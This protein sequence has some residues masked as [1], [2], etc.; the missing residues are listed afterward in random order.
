MPDDSA[1]GAPTKQCT[2]C[3]VHL[4]RAAF[5][6]RRASKDGLQPTCRDCTRAY[7]ALHRVQHADRITEYRAGRAEEQRAYMAAWRPGY[8]AANRDR[9]AAHQAEY[10]R[11]NAV[12]YRR[13]AAEW[14]R[15]NPERAAARSREYRRTHL[16]QVTAQQ[17]EWHL[18]NPERSSATIAARK[19]RKRGADAE[20]I[21]RSVVWE[22]DGGTCRLCGIPA[23]PGQWHLEHLV[24]LSRGGP[25][26][27]ANVA[28]SHPACNLAKSTRTLAEWEA[29][30]QAG[31]TT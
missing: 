15:A 5:H 24:P 10:Q 16:A 18:R 30:R 20:R 17:R 9:I 14:V 4:P 29:G 13:R 2:S 23:D 25:H 27:Y 22:R 31:S 1:A 26:T 12:T 28:V 19:A 6:A 8:Y 11:A 7:K 3:L 21:Y